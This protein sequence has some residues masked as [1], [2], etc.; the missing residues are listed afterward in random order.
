[1]VAVVVSLFSATT[2]GSSLV[3][4]GGW[5]QLRAF[6]VAAVHP[7]TSADFLALTWDSTRTT[8][9]Y[10]V[11]GTVLAMVIGVLGGMVLAESWWRRTPNPGSRPRAGW[12]A[13]R[14]LVTVPRGVHEAVWGLALV[15]VL[16]LDPL[17]GILAIGIPFGAVSAKVVSELVDETAGGAYMALRATGAGRLASLLYG[18]LPAAGSDIVSYG[19]YRFECAIR[20][21]AILG[22]IGAGGLGF[23][24]AL[25][26]QA[27]RY[28]EMWTLT[29]ALIAVSGLADLWS[30]RL[31]RG[32]RPGRSV[33]VSLVLAAFLVVLSVLHLDVDVT[34]LWAPA[35]RQLAV[36]TAAEAWPP[37]VAGTGVSG[38]FRLSLDTVQMSILGIAGATAGA[39]AMAFLAARGGGPVRRITSRLAR[40]VLLVARAVPPPVWAFVLL[41]VLFPGMLPGAVAL[42][43]Y[44]FGILGR[45]MAEV[46][47]N[48]DQRPAAALRT[49]GAPGPHAFLYGAVPLA[50]PRFT[51]Y[52]LYRWEVALRETVIVGAVGAGGLGRLLAQQ[53]AAFDYAAAL[54]TVIALIVLSGVVDLISAS[55]R[56]SLR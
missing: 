36:R 51:A 42:A 50:A 19:F 14:A 47:E 5:P 46:V 40:S 9:A 25:S 49:L 3:N 15:S 8:V 43:V 7:E 10:A 12:Y 48:L 21:A 17:V 32:S 34:S 16:G 41:L 1:L 55:V 4:M 38:L 52:A 45:L 20:A 39:A 23:Q 31:R 35:T 24:L 54:G 29:Y 28:E 37:S 33:R 53:L 22:I 30:S 27:L 13:A 26:F 18:V 11:L 6:A 2:G 44:N 56:H